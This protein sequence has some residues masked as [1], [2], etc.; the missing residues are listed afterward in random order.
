MY[1]HL[2]ECKIIV[3]NTVRFTIEMDTSGNEI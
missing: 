3:D 2:W 1:S